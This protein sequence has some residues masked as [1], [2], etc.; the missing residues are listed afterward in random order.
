MKISIRIFRRQLLHRPRNPNLP[1]QRLPVKAHCS[2]RILRQLHT[3]LA[4]R[5]RVERKPSFVQAFHQH[6]PHTGN[7]ARRSRSQRHR[8][9][10]V[11]LLRL[12]ILHP[13]TKRRNRITPRS[14]AVAAHS[15][16][17]SNNP[18]LNVA[19]WGSPAAPSPKPSPPSY[20]AN[21][22]F[23]FSTNGACETCCINA[24]AFRPHTDR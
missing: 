3:L 4:L 10:I 15:E 14:H 18:V 12:G 23:V 21:I 9:R 16:H 17:P 20:F 6:N 13:R 5:I 7:P 22:S 1:T 8:I 11:P 24:A 19:P 2:A